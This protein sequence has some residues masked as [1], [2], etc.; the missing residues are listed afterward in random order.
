[1]KRRGMPDSRNVLYTPR[2]S[3]FAQGFPAQAVVPTVSWVPV[4]NFSSQSSNVYL[5]NVRGGLP[6]CGTNLVPQPASIAALRQLQLSQAA[7]AAASTS[8]KDELNL[9][10]RNLR[11]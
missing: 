9:N 2:V 11:L 10:I 8:H 7:G 1:M 5:S 4:V 3:S 6:T